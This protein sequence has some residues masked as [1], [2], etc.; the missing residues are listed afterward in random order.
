[1]IRKLILAAT[2]IIGTPPTNVS[3]IVAPA[4]ADARIAGFFSMAFIISTI[5]A[6]FFVIKGGMNYVMS[7]GDASKVKSAQ[8]EI[9]YALIG[10][11][12]SLTG[13]V[14]VSVVTNLLGYNVPTTIG[15]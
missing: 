7:A 4:D 12:I 14:I 2:D 8:T 3:G 10:L 13:F 9:Q 11:V 1:M 6:T 15:L 5:L